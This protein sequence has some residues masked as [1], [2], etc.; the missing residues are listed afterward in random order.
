MIIDLRLFN[1][2]VRTE[3][4]FDWSLIL[5]TP[6]GFQGFI[7]LVV[8][9]FNSSFK[10]TQPKIPANT[11]TCKRILSWDQQTPRQ[12]TVKSINTNLLINCFKEL[13]NHSCV[14]VMILH[15][16]I[17]TQSCCC[18]WENLSLYLTLHPSVSAV[19]RSGSRW[20][21]SLSR[22]H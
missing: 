3:R 20:F 14:R 8:L 17:N 16:L 13:P 15:S 2:C 4:V 11:F 18:R 9:V 22:E 6:P 12:T 5:F 1:D 19:S 21:L 7:S 10:A